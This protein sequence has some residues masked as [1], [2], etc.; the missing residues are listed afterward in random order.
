MTSGIEKYIAQCEEIRKGNS[1][2]FLAE[3]CETSEKAPFRIRVAQPIEPDEVCVLILPPSNGR[4]FSLKG[5]NG[6]LKRVD[7]FVKNNPEFNGGDVRVCMA[8][9]HFGNFHEDK[10]ARDS[11]W[12]ELTSPH[13]FEEFKSDIPEV[14]REEILNPQYIEDIFNMA[15]LP[16]ISKDDGKSRVEQQQALR[17]IR[18]LNLIT[19]CHSGYVAMKLEQLMNKKMDE[20]GYSKGEQKQIKSQMMVLCYNPDCPKSLSEFYMVSIESAQDSHNKYNNY[21]REWL[22]MAPKDFG[23]CYM[24]KNWGRTLM[25]SQIDKYGIE[26][27]PPRQRKLMSAEE[28][29]NGTAKAKTTDEIGE[30]DWIGFEPTSNMSK[31]ACKMQKFANN[32]LINAVKNSLSQD[33]TGFVP[34]PKIQNLAASNGREKYDFAE[35]AIIGYRLEKQMMFTGKEKIDQYANW[36]RS[37]PVIEMD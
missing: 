34:L 22:L 8:V 24:P 35:A 23:V 20:L 37:I 13:Y 6:M 30:H 21:M 29:F 31:A 33:E 9:C 16:R 1:F 25:C 27:N 10:I 7:N 28:W 32:I 17:N 12:Y 4:K 2:A 11:L 36:R 14:S 3:R 19:R 5:H 18:K 15:I 26:G